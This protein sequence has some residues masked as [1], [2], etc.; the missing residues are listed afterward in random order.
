MKWNGIQF[1]SAMLN[2][3]ALKTGEWM[4][5]RHFVDGLFYCLAVIPSGRGGH[6]LL[7]STSRAGGGISFCATGHSSLDSPWQSKKWF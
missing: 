7:E 5:L 6:L 1:S 2:Y 3:G 4:S